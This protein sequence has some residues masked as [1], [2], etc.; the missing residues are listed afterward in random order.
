MFRK[1]IGS[2]VVSQ[3]NSCEINFRAVTRNVKETCISKILG[4]VLQSFMKVI[5]N[6]QWTSKVVWIELTQKIISLDHYIVSR[7][8]YSGAKKIQSSLFYFQLHIETFYS[9]S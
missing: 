8:L 9:R 5:G 4:F 3:H 1:R 7:E 2:R 6:S